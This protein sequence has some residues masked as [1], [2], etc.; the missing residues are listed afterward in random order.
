MSFTAAVSIFTGVFFGLA[1]VLQ[2]SRAQLAPALKNESVAE[3]LRR[4]QIRDVLIASGRDV[5][6]PF[7]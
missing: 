2:S 5:R 7:G 1:P 6:C 3:R 4:F